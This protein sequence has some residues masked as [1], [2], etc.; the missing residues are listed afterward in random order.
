MIPSLFKIFFV[1]VLVM[2]T[3]LLIANLKGTAK[4]SSPEFPTP[5]QPKSGLGL[6]IDLLA[7][8]TAAHGDYESLITKDDLLDDLLAVDIVLIGEA[9]YDRQDMQTAFE[10]IRLLAQRRKI[11]LAVER[12]PISF[13]PDLEALNNFED[14]K[15]RSKRML[16]L[17][18]DDEYQTVWG[19]NDPS[20]AGF[21]DP[22]QPQYPLNSP[23]AEVFESMMLWAACERVPVVGMDLP[24]SERASGFGE[25]ISYRNELW[26]NQIINFLENNQSNDYLVIAIGGINHFSNAPGSVQDKLHRNYSTYHFRSIGQRDVNYPSKKSKQVQDLAL[27]FQVDDIILDNPQFAVVRN[28]GSAMF[29]TP[30]DYW[31]AAHIV[32]GW[33]NSANCSLN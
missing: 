18:Q 24:L 8:L 2:L 17:M 6:P 20:Q 28:D 12:F 3:T 33:D 30:P 14:E 25:D 23:S 32:G 7:A 4:D 31:I 27:A 1:F 16:A 26:M 29:P 19:I 9:H 10:L 11:A 22:N 5:E 13:Q 21:S 15:L